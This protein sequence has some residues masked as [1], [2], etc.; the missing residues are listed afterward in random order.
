MAETNTTP[1]TGGGKIVSSS[2]LYETLQDFKT[3]HI[4]TKVDKEGGKGLSTNDLTTALKTAYDGAVSKSHTHSN[5]TVL[6]GITVED[7]EAWD[8]KA[9]SSHTHSNYISSVTT[10]GSGNAVTAISQSGNVLTVIKGSTFLTSHPTITTKTNT[11]SSASPAFGGSFTAI[12]G[13]TTDSN[14]HVTTYETKTVTLPSLSFES[15]A[16][17]LSTLT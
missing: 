7:I 11:T 16:L 2:Y 12:S 5:K 9:S 17:D 8:A 6:D 14:G 4:D 13:V 3:E 1:Y 10:S 15:T